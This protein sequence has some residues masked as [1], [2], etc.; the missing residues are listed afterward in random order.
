MTVQS[1]RRIGAEHTE[2]VTQ[3]YE[4]TNERQRE[5]LARQLLGRP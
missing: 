1:T 2:F 4:G 3:N 5:I